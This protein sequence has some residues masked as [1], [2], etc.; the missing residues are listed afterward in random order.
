ME[1]NSSEVGKQEIVTQLP[2][3]EQKA[4][5]SLAT[6][7]TA[8]EPTPKE[9][10]Q[11]KE[12]I[13]EEAIIREAAANSSVEPLNVEDDP[14][15]VKKKSLLGELFNSLK[16]KFAPVLKFLKKILGIK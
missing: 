11:L 6:E 1:N 14:L 8:I 9:L 12:V 13:K 2:P 10:D 7:T 3:P 15:P 4:E 16:M 5:A